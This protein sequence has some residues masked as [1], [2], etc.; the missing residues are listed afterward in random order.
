M[1]HLA[2]SIISNMNDKTSNM[3]NPIQS[4]HDTKSGST[5]KRLEKK[6]YNK[7]NGPF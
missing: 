4:G 5:P 3:A 6:F 2:F 1:V 7:K